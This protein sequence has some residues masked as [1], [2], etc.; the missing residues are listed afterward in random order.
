MTRD[1]DQLLPCGGAAAAMHKRIAAAD[2]M[3][4]MY[5]Y[6]RLRVARQW[7]SWPLL[8]T[9]MSPERWGEDVIALVTQCTP[10]TRDDVLDEWMRI[11]NRHINRLAAALGGGDGE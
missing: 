3:G 9:G 10:L 6:L 5:A 2:L 8:T 1:D 7:L 11:G 4:I